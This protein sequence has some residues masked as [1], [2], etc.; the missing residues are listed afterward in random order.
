MPKTLTPVNVFSPTIPNFPLAGNNE[1][2]T[3]GALE[4]AIQTVL[5]NSLNANTRLGTL[6]AGVKRTVRYSSLSNLS[7]ATGFVDGDT[8]IVDG[9]GDYTFYNP[10]A[11]TVDG[12]WILSSSISGNARW[13]HTGYVLKG[14]TNGLATLTG[15]RLAQDVRDG[16]ILTQH[17]GNNQVTATKLALGAV[18]GH[19]G[20]TPANQAGD[21]FT[22]AVTVNGTF[23][24]QGRFFR[25]VSFQPSSGVGWYRIIGGANV[26]GGRFELYAEWNAQVSKITLEGYTAGFGNIAGFQA[27]QAFHYSSILI[28]QVRWGQSGGADAYLDIYVASVTGRGSEPVYVRFQGDVYTGSAIATNPAYN[29][30]AGSTNLVLDVSKSSFMHANGLTTRDKVFFNRQFNTTPDISVAIGDSDTGFN[31]ISDGTV[32]L[33]ANGLETARW[34]T[35]AAVLAANKLLGTQGHSASGGTGG[36]AF[37]QVHHELRNAG[38]GIRWAWSLFGT[39]TGG[40]FGS[41]LVLNRYDDSSNA[42]T[43]GHVRFIRAGMT[44]EFGGVVRP[45]S[46]N[47]F[48]LG[49]STQRWAVLW[50][51]NGAIQTSD[52]RAK[53]DVQN[54]PL[55]LEFVRQLRP[56]AY[57]YK[58][59]QN[60]P[61]EAEREVEVVE[62]LEDGSEVTTW[63]R[64]IETSYEPRPGKRLHYGLIAQEVKAVLERLGVADFGDWVLTDYGNPDSEQGLR[65]DQFISPIIR[66]IQELDER[67]SSVEKK[68]S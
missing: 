24:T 2:M 44:T 52:A 34:G 39:E 57:R 49:S 63:K 55:G 56:V 53:T 10:S 43:S 61:V 26:F 8:V 28:S 36:I 11:L 21:T 46:D 65:Y 23:T 5:N 4:S 64:V 25:E 17:L 33:F 45:V 47:T 14:S 41:D 7:A 27:V 42:N 12:L 9:Y 29:P 40:Q 22:G 58:I 60:A 15:G 54:A 31:W 3:I 37:G 20:Y 51:A 66:A 38:G 68:A 30:A 6:E 19:L 13:V 16:S 67:L 50:A 32:A 48:G 62:K 1:P 18:V 59:G 35:N